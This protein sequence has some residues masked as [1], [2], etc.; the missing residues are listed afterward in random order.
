[1][2]DVV[3]IQEQARRSFFQWHVLLVVKKKR[4]EKKLEDAGYRPETVRKIEEN[5]PPVVDSD[6]LALLK[7][8]G[9]PI[10]T[11]LTPYDL[12]DRER[13]TGIRFFFFTCPA[14]DNEHDY[15]LGF[16]RQLSNGSYEHREVMSVG[17]DD[18]DYLDAAATKFNAALKSY[19]VSVVF[20]ASVVWSS[21]HGGV[22]LDWTS[23]SS[24]LVGVDSDS[25]EN[26]AWFQEDTVFDLPDPDETKTRKKK[27]RRISLNGR[28]SLF[29]D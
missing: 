16:V 8:I 5:L 2:S 14:F 3:S 23:V 28:K 9:L 27:K 24:R 4:L 20:N 7:N 22:V 11:D 10:P 25:S 13:V 12:P 17:L 21:F 29:S 6:E 1:M 26:T 19:S 15:V 18:R